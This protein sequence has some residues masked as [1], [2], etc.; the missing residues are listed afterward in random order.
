MIAIATNRRYL[1]SVRHFVIYL[2]SV[3]QSSDS[4]VLSLHVLTLSLRYLCP[5]K[6]SANS[7]RPSCIVSGDEVKADDRVEGVEIEDAGDSG[8]DITWS[9]FDIV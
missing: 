8:I 7:V 6:P 4:S 1:S 2:F 5:F 3:R 9:F